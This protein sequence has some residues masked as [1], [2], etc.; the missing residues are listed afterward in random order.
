MQVVDTC[1]QGVAIFS[2]CLDAQFIV[3][4]PT[5]GSTNH[6]SAVLL[7][8]TIERYHH[9]STVV[10]C[11]AHAIVVDNH[12]QTCCQ[13]FFCHTGLLSPG[14]MKMREP[15]SLLSEGHHTTG[16]LLQFDGLFLAIAN[17]RP[18][19]NHIALVVGFI[20]EV[21]EEVVFLILQGDDGQVALL[22]A[23]RHH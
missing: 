20:I 10:H 23:T 5:Q 18:G 6:A 21:H 12:L 2:A 17:H 7:R 9:L 8:F 16:I 13:G 22:S 19:L 11:C 3:A 1:Q 14:T 4:C 15:G